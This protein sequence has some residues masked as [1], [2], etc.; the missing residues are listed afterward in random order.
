MVGL[1]AAAPCLPPV[2]ASGHG[3]PIPACTISAK[4]VNSCR[5]W[6]GAE[7]GGYGVTGFRARMLEHEARIGRQ[8]DIVHAY[9]GAG[10]VGA[11]Q[12]HP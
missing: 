4:L 7:S 11:D 2:A 1:V 12:R 6:L 10:N 8:V 3:P 9:L 5:P